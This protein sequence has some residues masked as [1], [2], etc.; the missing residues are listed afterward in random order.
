MTPCVPVCQRAGALSRQLV[1]VRASGVKRVSPIGTG[2]FLRQSLP[3]DALGVFALTLTNVVVGSRVH[4]Q[5]GDGSTL[6][7]QIAGATSVLINLQA[8]AYGS[9]RNDLT[10]R[11][12]K[13]SSSPK[14]LPFET[15]ATAI[16]GAQSVFVAQVPD[17]IA[18]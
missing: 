10:I 18:A 3:T 5:A 12:R 7:D 8:Y 6:Y 17:T 11:V 2:A 16:V 15:Y 4:V 1:S 9:P 14:Y 13:S